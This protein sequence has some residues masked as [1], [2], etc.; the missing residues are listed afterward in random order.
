M[1]GFERFARHGDIDSAE[2]GRLL[3]SELSCVACHASE[4]Q[5]LQPKRG[6]NLS[7]AGV[8]LSSDWMKR[9]IAA[10]HETKPGTTMPHI[11]ATLPAKDREATVVAITEFLR[12][13]Q[14]EFPVIK[15]GGA[16]AVPHEF[17]KHGDPSAGRKLFHRIGCVACH[18]PDP[19]YETVETQP[20][21]LSLVLEQLSP[22]EIEEMGL[23]SA[24]RRVA[25]VPLHELSK[26]YSAQSLT[27][28]LLDPHRT[29]ISGRMP[30]FDLNVVQA[31]DIA[32]WI[33]QRDGSGPSMASEFHPAKVDQPLAEKGRVLFAAL[34]CANCHSAGKVKPSATAKAW[35]TLRATD[36][37]CLNSA[38]GLPDFGLNDD[39][40][41]AIS[42]AIDSA[43]P[44]ATGQGDSLDADA[45][46]R[47]TLL[48]FNC[49][50]C[51]QRD[52]IGGVGRYRKAC[53]ETFGNIDVGDEGRL[54]PPLTGVGHK[55]LPKSLEDVFSGKAKLR[56]HMTIQMPGFPQAGMRDLP[57]QLSRADQQD[58]IAEQELFPLEDEHMAAGR[59][60][61]DTGCVQC[62]SLQGNMLPGVVGVELSDVTN[63]VRPQWFRD[64]LL[65]PAHLKPGTRMPSFFP[66]GKGQLKTVY[67]GDAS[68]QISALWHYLKQSA[69][70][71]L[72]QKLEKSRSQNFELIPEDR[73]L[74]LRTFMKD[75]GTHAIAVGLPEKISF[76][77]DAERV[78]LATAWKGRFLD[79]QG[80]WFVRFAPPAEQLGD[81]SIVFPD[82]SLFVQDNDAEM[83]FQGFRLDPSGVP[84]FLYQMAGCDVQD[85][86]TATTD[87]QLRR[88]LTIR[89]TAVD[90]TIWIRPLSGKTP[91]QKDDFTMTDENGL[92]VTVVGLSS[93]GEVR[94]NK[95]GYEWM[96]PLPA[97]AVVEMEL[98]YQ[99]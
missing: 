25:S 87:R 20:T 65:D 29:R 36:H 18:E 37:S 49:F 88:K 83:R 57:T 24:T 76:A 23:A 15:A 74:L 93:D 59:I 48:Q 56:P 86:I 21:V 98:H 60:L 4:Q 77:F 79:A 27:H 63:R 46:A 67:G 1:A 12:A 91:G 42:S 9:F 95:N 5:S 69:N 44:S 89:R 75:A 99:W 43:M 10:P 73:P 68:R 82:A 2:G 64:F 92:K 45:L 94:R 17:W 55:L 7:V 81:D 90:Q 35:G 16:S 47:H 19:T 72:P 13:Q 54:P 8:Q 6:P 62:H 61:L 50:A 32:A 51:H 78:R 71:P 31:A 22:D 11:L 38:T 70:Q 66:D 96:L 53:F 34:G 33:T 39:Q 30:K 97:N 84:T 52:K 41:Q 14:A 40:Q 85:R 28:F 58:E 3:I 80:T 26:K